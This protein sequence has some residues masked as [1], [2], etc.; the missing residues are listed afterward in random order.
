MLG[1]RTVANLHVFLS[2]RFSGR[3]LDALDRFLCSPG[4]SKIVRICG[5]SLKKWSANASIA[6]GDTFFDFGMDLATSEPSKSCWRLR[7]N[8]ILIKLQFLTL[9]ATRVIF[10]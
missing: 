9:E 1:E 5:K 2:H 10:R 3:L 4:S 7:N 6:L 8:N